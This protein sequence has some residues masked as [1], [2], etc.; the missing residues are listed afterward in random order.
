MMLSD[1]PDGIV[2][3]KALLEVMDDRYSLDNSIGGNKH[4]EFDKTGEPWTSS[5]P[6]AA[7]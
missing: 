5:A 3:S 7:S 2:F 6:A 4:E 1:A